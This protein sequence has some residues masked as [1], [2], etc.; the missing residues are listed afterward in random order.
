MPSWL[1]APSPPIVPGRPH[2]ALVLVPTSRRGSRARRG[3][4]VRPRRVGARSARVSRPLRA[5]GVAVFAGRFLAAPYCPRSSHQ[6]GEPIPLSAREGCAEAAERGALFEPRSGTGPRA[7]GFVGSSC[8]VIV[9]RRVRAGLRCPTASAIARPRPPAP[10][11]P[12]GSSELR[13]ASVRAP[14]VGASRRRGR[15]SRGDVLARRKNSRVGTRQRRPAG[16]AEAVFVIFAAGGLVRCSNPDLCIRPRR[17]KRGLRVSHSTFN[18]SRSALH[19]GSRGPHQLLLLR[20]R[21]RRR[22]READGDRPGGC[23]QPCG[24]D[25]RRS[26]ALGRVGAGWRC[27]APRKHPLSRPRRLGSPRSLVRCDRHP[28]AE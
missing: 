20:V 24:P 25:P 7:F 16:R 2:P 6:N 26:S 22:A 12:S 27:S 14:S 8:R 17:E 10:C 28:L 1:A 23:V 9:L 13:R 21:S 3:S 11:G 18:P 19:R 15:G 4:P 5:T